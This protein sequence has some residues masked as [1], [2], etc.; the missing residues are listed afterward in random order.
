MP[1]S[2]SLRKTLRTT[3][4]F[5]SLPNQELDA[6][7]VLLTCK[8][9]RR[10]EVL[11]RKGTHP[12][13]IGIL[14]TG[15]IIIEYRDSGSVRRSTSLSA[16]AFLQPCDFR[17]G[18]KPSSSVSA[19]AKTDATLYIMRL[20]QLGGLRSRCPTLYNLLSRTPQRRTSSLHWSRLWAV[21]IALLIVFL[22][23]P[24]SVS[25]MSD[26]LYLRS[27]QLGA[28]GDHQRALELLEYAVFFDPT[29]ALSYNQ[30]GYIFTKMG[31]DTELA[32]KAF[33]KAL[34][35]D[36]A[37]GP[38]LNNLA[39][40][41]FTS[42]LADQAIVL[43]QKAAQAQPNTAAIKYNLG[44]I[45]LEQND[46][47]EAIRAFKEASRIDPGW[48][49]PYLQLSSV[50]LQL[51]DYAEAE[52]SARTATHLDPAQQ[53][54]HL[55][56][57]IA[58]YY[59]DKDHQALASIE[60]ALAIDPDSIVFRFYKAMILRDLGEHEAALLTLQ[61]LLESSGD[62]QQRLRIVAEIEAIL[63]LYPEAMG[64]Q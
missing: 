53:S 58:S 19:Y 25:I 57:A 32:A 40:T 11:W 5:R 64:P 43:Q 62:P 44:L 12:D 50:Y 23:W 3:P 2:V 42:G 59:R 46:Y 8:E 15:E 28:S 16:G 61:Q 48:A 20:D 10:G 9:Y 38:A 60:N 33:T 37:S 14:Q 47:A 1:S 13:F 49:L 31:A 34:S 29:S 4:I 18:N 17:D 36:A 41:Y 39:I 26:I 22:V 27:N 52:R 21:T 30:Q 54:A 7:L 63:R 56:L 45:L 6:V 35:V 24:D 51:G 55:C